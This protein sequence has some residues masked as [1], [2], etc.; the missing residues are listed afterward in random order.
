MN[1]RLAWRHSSAWMRVMYITCELN[2]TTNLRNFFRNRWRSRGRIW[3]IFCRYNDAR[4]G[5]EISMTEC[6]LF[7][8]FFRSTITSSLQFAKLIVFCRL[9]TSFA[10]LVVWFFF[11]FDT[12]LITE[13]KRIGSVFW[14]QR[15]QN[16]LSY[17]YLFRFCYI[18]RLIESFFM[19]GKQSPRQSTLRIIYTYLY[20]L[21]EIDP[22]GTLWYR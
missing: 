6:S 10:T 22:F 8:W 20:D 12:V 18:I 16:C 9:T 2:S 13:G 11:I 21:F 17:L 14:V 19:N 7:T 15:W 1:W 3:S 5:H 4:A